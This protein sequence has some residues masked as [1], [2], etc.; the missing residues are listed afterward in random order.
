M[1]HFEKLA[2]DSAQYKPSLYLDDTL[3]VW[4]HGP[5]RLQSFFSYLSSLRPSIHFTME[6]ESDS[7]V[8]FQDVLFIT[9]GT[10][11]ATKVYRKPTHTG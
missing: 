9:K 4:P 7:V 5:E 10:A 2:L 11:W 8:P 3:V 6:I 1:E